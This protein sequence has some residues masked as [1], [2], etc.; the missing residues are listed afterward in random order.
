MKITKIF[1]IVI[2]LIC[3]V[4][5]CSCDKKQ[6]VISKLEK[7][8]SGLCLLDPKVATESDLFEAE[9]Q[10]LKIRA[11]YAPVKSEYSE[12]ELKH[13]EELLQQSEDQI[14]K[15]KQKRGW[16]ESKDNAKDWLHKIIDK[17]FE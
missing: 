17:V 15:L 7:L 3:A 14:E 10:L 2:V 13:I 4:L 11:E 5:L 16:E 8:N 12:I 9:A 1:S 6:Q